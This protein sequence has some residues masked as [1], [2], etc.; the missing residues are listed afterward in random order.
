M[1]WVAAGVVL[2]AVAVSLVRRAGLFG[3][4]T[5]HRHVALVV[6]HPDDEAMFFWPTLSQLRA[7]GVNISVL[8]L[9]TGNFDGLG[10]V[11]RQEMERSCLQ[12]GV[13]GDA[14]EILDVPELQ[15]GWH[16][17]SP[18]AVAAK[19]LTFLARRK[20]TV[21]LTFD[22][23]GVSGHP[24]H[25][26]A[27][28]GMLEAWQRAQDTKS[29]QFELLMLRTV[30]LYMKYL[31]PLGLLLQQQLGNDA[32]AMLGN[33]FSCLNALSTHWSQLVWYRVLFA[34]ASHYGY[35]NTFVRCG[36][37]EPTLKKDQ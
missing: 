9:S 20:A 11:R 31:G 34:L 19:A 32:V 24:N 2:V 35:I 29:P 7:A 37:T 36:S 6:A 14:L 4:L 27:S 33:P 21:V 28:E 15:D 12:L 18:D 10:D 25:I 17:W 3:L 22:G 23:Q 13:S 16:K 26:S 8:C 1:I 30:P 5:K